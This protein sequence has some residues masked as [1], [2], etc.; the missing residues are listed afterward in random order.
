MMPV[1]QSTDVALGQ[2]SKVG[3]PQGYSVRALL[4]LVCLLLPNHGKYP[5]P[6]WLQVLQL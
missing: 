2:P 1:V 3:W 6:C 5:N 4:W